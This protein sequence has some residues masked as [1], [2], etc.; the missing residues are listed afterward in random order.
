MR[1]Y[2]RRQF[3][4][5]LGK[6][7]SDA[8]PQNIEKSLFNWAIRESR[9]LQDTPSWEN[10]YFRERYKRKFLTIQYNLKEPLSF[11]KERI[12]NGE[13]RSVDVV[14]LRPEE[15][16]KTGPYAMKIEEQRVLQMKMDAA[17]GKLDEKYEGAFTCGKC[18]SKKTTYFEMQTRSADE[19]MT[20]FVTCLNC[21]KRWKS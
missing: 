7:V 3:A 17:Q 12:L 18:K 19:P 2:V 14:E 20:I 4:T 6:A 9:R 13:I 15:L 16:W 5:L 21:G 11:L 1:D 8:I 10:R